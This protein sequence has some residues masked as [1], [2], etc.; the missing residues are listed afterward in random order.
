MKKLTCFVI[1]VTLGVALVG[2]ASAASRKARDGAPRPGQ[3]RN[4]RQPG[5]QNYRGGNNDRGRARPGPVVNG[6]RLVSPGTLARLVVG[7]FRLAGRV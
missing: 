5:G 3:A 7:H 6:A 1:T 2:P 4:K